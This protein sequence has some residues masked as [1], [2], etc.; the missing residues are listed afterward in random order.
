MSRYTGAVRFRDKSVMYFVYDGTVDVAR[1]R[2]Y[3]EASQARA[4]WN[5]EQDA[6]DV[7]ANRE[8][9]EAV[10]VMPYYCHDDKRVAFMSRASKSQMVTLGYLSPIEY[11]EILGLTT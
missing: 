10:E 8:G 5:D 6:V 2:L 3:R 9:E 1:P 11:R 4:A 7:G